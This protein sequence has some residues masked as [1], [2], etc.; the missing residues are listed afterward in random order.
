MSYLCSAVCS[1][2]MPTL[3]DCS[4]VAKVASFTHAYI[5]CRRI[6]FACL[7]FELQEDEGR[8]CFCKNI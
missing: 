7:E 5:Y 8:I 4:D 2:A 6:I 1:V 3:V